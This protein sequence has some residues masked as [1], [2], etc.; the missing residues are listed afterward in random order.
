MLLIKQ[1]LLRV[2][3]LSLGVIAILFYQR[4]YPIEERVIRTYMDSWTP[5]VSTTNGT[6]AL[7]TTDKLGRTI[8]VRLNPIPTVYLPV[9]CVGGVAERI[10]MCYKQV[11]VNNE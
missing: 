4:F 9:F 10:E 8:L 5:L 2:V 1:L 11:E 3:W 6:V 7:L